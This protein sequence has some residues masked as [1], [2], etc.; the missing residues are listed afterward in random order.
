MKLID[1]VTSEQG[2]KDHSSTHISSFS[3]LQSVS[4]MATGDSSQSLQYGFRVAY[5]TICLLIAEVTP[6]IVDAYHEE[7]IVMPTTPDDWMVIANNNSRKWQ[8][9]HC[10]GALHGK[11]VAI[12]KPINAGSYYYN[13]KNFHSIVLM[14][15]VEV[16]NFPAFFCRIVIMLSLCCR[17]QLLC[18]CQQSLLG[19][20][21]DVLPLLFVVSLSLIVASGRYLLALQ[22][23]GAFSTT[24]RLKGD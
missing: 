15:L 16:A 19:R 20:R 24:S 7:V 14:A 13:Y 21:A 17:Q 9:H 22:S 8:Y 23:C 4:Y 11:H 1:H 3:V 12:R 10:L 2:I 5:N 18:C 6:A